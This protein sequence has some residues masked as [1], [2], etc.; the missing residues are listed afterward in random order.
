M[1]AFILLPCFDID[2]ET[3]GRTC[4]NIKH[5]RCWYTKVHKYVHPCKNLPHYGTLVILCKLFLLRRIRG[6]I[7]FIWNKGRVTACNKQKQHRPCKR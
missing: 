2:D 7:F 5:W 4:E 3:I 1:H 6:L